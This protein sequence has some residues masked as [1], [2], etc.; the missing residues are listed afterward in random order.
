MDPIACFQAPNKLKILI[1]K[2]TDIGGM[3]HDPAD[4][5]EE[6]YPV[7]ID[8]WHS[9]K[10]FGQFETRDGFQALHS[11]LFLRGSPLFRKEDQLIKGVYLLLQGQEP[12]WSM[13][14]IP[15]VLR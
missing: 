12:I 6:R 2:L 4:H 13:T 7:R 5:Y 10:P 8:W 11:V 3:I 14:I 15:C 1:K 9:S